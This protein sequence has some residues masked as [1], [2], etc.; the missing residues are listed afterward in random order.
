MPIAPT[1][2][3]DR[4]DSFDDFWRYYLREH[5]SG[6]NR[7]LH[8]IGT[9][10]GL[11]LA[12]YAIARR[13]PTLLLLALLTGYGAAWAGH[14]LIERNRPATIGNPLWSLRA[15]LKMLALTMCGRIDSEMERCS[16]SAREQMPATAA[17]SAASS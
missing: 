8:V 7:A 3:A 12:A 14:F 16:T 5:A 10:A 15:D 1:Q 17:R 13:R 2:P 11:T 4:F 6:A 9:S